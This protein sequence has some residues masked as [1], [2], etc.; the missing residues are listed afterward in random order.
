MKTKLL[1]KSPKY[2][3]A[4]QQH[5]QT[6]D[7]T[8]KPPNYAQ[9]RKCQSFKMMHKL[10]SNCSKAQLRALEQEIKEK[11]QYND[12]LMFDNILS[13]D[14][15]YPIYMLFEVIEVCRKSPNDVIKERDIMTSRLR[16]TF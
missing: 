12:V 6:C 1:T 13:E 9:G 16:Q 14:G 5:E 11:T 2:D 10:V 4:I 15:E 3:T 7:G 8:E